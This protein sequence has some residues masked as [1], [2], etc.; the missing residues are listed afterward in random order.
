MCTRKP[1]HPGAILREDG[2][3]NFFIRK[4]DLQKR[5]FSKVLYDWGCC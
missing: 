3:G 2:F 1:T 5:D 4:S